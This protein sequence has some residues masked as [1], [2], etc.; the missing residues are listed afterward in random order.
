MG[1]AKFNAIM[2]FFHGNKMKSLI[3]LFL[4]ELET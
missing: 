1:N 3:I 2:Q 4:G